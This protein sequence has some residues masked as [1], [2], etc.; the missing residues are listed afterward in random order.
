MAGAGDLLMI[1]DERVYYSTGRDHTARAECFR[2]RSLTDQPT[3]KQPRKAWTQGKTIEGPPVEGPPRPRLG[4]LGNHAPCAGR[5][6]VGSAAETMAITRRRRTVAASAA[7]VTRNLRQFVTRKLSAF[8]LHRRA[9]SEAA[10]LS[11][12]SRRPGSAGW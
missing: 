1:P 7:L 11:R 9:R 10:W 4:D 5:L 3:N 12:E 8:T 6:I 2:P